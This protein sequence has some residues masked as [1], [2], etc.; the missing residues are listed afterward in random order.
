MF[1]ESLV[2]NNEPRARCAREEKLLLELSAALLRGVKQY[3]QYC[4][5]AHRV[6][7]DFSLPTALD[8]QTVRKPPSSRGRWLM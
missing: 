2:I 4:F 3:A 8:T 6:C 5:E 1:E 7:S